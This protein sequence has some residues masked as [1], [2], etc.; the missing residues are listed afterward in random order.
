[1]NDDARKSVI[2]KTVSISEALTEELRS[3]VLDGD[4]PAGSLV[5]ETEVASTYGV[6]RPTAKSAIQSLTHDGL[7][8]RR[9][10]KPAYVPHL[11]KSDIEDLYFVRIQIETS[12]VRHLAKNN[13]APSAALKAADELA[14][15][16]EDA[17]SSVFAYT[18][19][20]FHASLVD[21]TNSERLIELYRTLLDEIRLSMAQA[22]Y[23]LGQQ[24]ISSEHHGIYFAIEER[25]ELL[26]VDRLTD[27]LN[28]L[29]TPFAPTKPKNSF[30][31]NCIAIDLPSC[32]FDKRYEWL[33]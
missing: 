15:L 24:R 9:P 25:N 2:S 23:A 14:E 33:K 22:R 3:K 5:T 11:S 18:D 13:L 8:R 1:M 20:A 26:A 7:L 10:N 21:A 32:T 17:P 27:H 28:G 29:A 16:P 31:A 6:S 12:V 19:L 4:I 30:V